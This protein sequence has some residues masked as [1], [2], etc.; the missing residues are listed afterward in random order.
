M[1]KRQLEVQKMLAG[2]EA[3][4]I[5]QLKQVYIR[6]SKDCEARIRDLSARTDMENLQSIIWQKQYQEALKKQIDGVLD[7][8]GTESFAM[9]ADYL[10]GCYEDSFL[11]T[12]YDLQGQGI[13]LLFPFNQEEAVQ[14]I[15]VDSKI[16]QGLY[17]RMGEDVG[18]LKN[19]I[20]SELSRGVSNGS[21]W[22]M[23]AKR[24][25]FGMN[26]PFMKAFNRAIGIARTEGHRVQQEAA[27]HCQQRAKEKGADVVKQWDSTLDNL[28]RPHHRELDG[29]VR[30]VGEPFEVAGKKAM[31]PGGFGDPSEDCNCRCCLLQR[32]K[33]VLSEEEYYIKW[34]G[35]KNKLVRVEAKTYNEFK[36][37]AKALDI[38][39]EHRV[40]NYTKDDFSVKERV[41]FMEALAY[42]PEKVKEA[43]KDTVICVGS[44][45][46]MY[47]PAKDTIYIGKNASLA[48]AIHEI[49]HAIEGKLFDK[50]KVDFVKRQCVKGLSKQDLVRV[51][52]K[53][54][55]GNE[56]EIICVRSEKLI[57]LYQ[58]R[59]YV[60]D[61]PDALNP[62]GS[63]NTDL[64]EEIISVAV[65]EY[66]LRPNR[67]K[68]KNRDLYNL[69]DEV[70]R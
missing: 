8:L 51:I 24:I 32:A 15:Q 30:E 39:L 62:D 49:G 11:G 53:D 52:A 34:H 43:L 12:L 35:E 68:S 33:W 26:S 23:V 69:V 28:T 56:E 18:K 9:I 1:N 4:I 3:E 2:N 41:T 61:I 65:Q 60:D 54:S 66:S 17:Q 14:A 44:K 45:G 67:M 7:R 25:A 48:E 64:M 38:S 20:R 46:S 13:P 19:S 55:S 58:G 31:H 37:A 21:S 50:D 16:S 5:R 63:I 70:M 36:A 22:N 57:S 10:A 29:Q 40:T 27:L 59:V 47:N 42:M 6:A